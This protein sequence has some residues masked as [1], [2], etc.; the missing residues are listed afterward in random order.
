MYDEELEKVILYYMIFE[1]GNF[2]IDIS[3]FV[4]V[5]HQKIVKAIKEL[6]AE[7][8]EVSMISIAEKIQASKSKVLSY[9][10]DL[11]VYAAGITADTAYN[12]LIEYSKKRKV[13]ELLAST[14]K[15]MSDF[16]SKNTESIDIWI[17]KIIES[18]KKISQRNER[19]KS[20]KEQVFDTMKEI[21]ANYLNR[22]DKSLYTGLVDLD[23]E[24][25]GLHKQ[26]LT[27]IGARPRNRKD[28]ISIANS[29]TYCE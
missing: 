28:Y 4:N 11:N 22:N 23:N 7:N 21:E 3:D 27:I 9:L 6:K 8:A 12:R 29:R 18:L 13:Y 2:E 26:E 1:Q 20:F 5:S 17:E 10:A 24:L 19:V 15:G 14:T 25:L 16:E